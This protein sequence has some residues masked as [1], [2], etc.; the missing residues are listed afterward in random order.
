M[1]T[2]TNDVCDDHRHPRWDVLPTNI[3]V[4][5][6]H[7]KHLALALLKGTITPSAQELQQIIPFVQNEILKQAI[8]LQIMDTRETR[9]F[10]GKPEDFSLDLAAL[11]S[12]FKE[13]CGAPPVEDAYRFPNREIVQG[14]QKFN[15]AYREYLA[16][17]KDVNLLEREEVKDALKETDSLNEIWDLVRDARCESYYTHVRRRALKRLL[18]SIG[19]E[20]FY[21]SALPPGVPLWRFK[22]ID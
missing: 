7:E 1:M 14:V 11:R 10:F 13:F 6:S 20:A 3:I 9:C 22:S 4:G 8:E 19:P 21:S 18:E 12:R 16:A 5:S 15:R 2:A 17:K